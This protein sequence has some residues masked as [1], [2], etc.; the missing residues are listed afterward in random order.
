M[1]NFLPYQSLVSRL[2]AEAGASYQRRMLVVSGE[3]NWCDEFASWIHEEV[4]NE[5]SLWVSESPL[6]SEKGISANKSKMLLGREID[7]LVIDCHDGLDANALAASCGALCGGGLLVLLT[8][9]WER[10]ALLDR[11]VGDYAS[12]FIQHIQRSIQSAHITH[13]S[14]TG[15]LLTAPVNSSITA[16][17]DYSD[18]Q[19]AVAGVI[20][21][22]TGHR[23]R[24]LVITAD[25]GRGKSA[26]LGL[27]SAWLMRNSKLKI[28]V[29]AP[30]SDAVDAV[31]R[32]AAQ[33]LDVHQHGSIL[34]YE[35][36]KLEFIA[37]DELI[38]SSLE[39]DLVLVDE[40]AAIPVPMLA[41]LLKRY[42]RIAFSTTV[43]GYEGTGR[44][45][46]IRFR[47]KLD[48]LTPQ[49]KQLQLAKPVRWAENDPVE[50]WLFDLLF[51][52]AGVIK[53]TESHTVNLKKVRI[54]RLQQQELLKNP[55]LLKQIFGLLVLAHYQ[56]SPNDLR[57]MLD[58]PALQLWVTCYEDTVL[59]AALI[60]KEGPI[61]S[62]LQEAVWLGERRLRG[63]L[64]PQAL[65]AHSGFR[66][67]AQ[68]AYW[69]IM[70]ITVH[71]DFQR[72]GL[73]S[74]LLR[75][76]A[77]QALL[78]GVDIFGSSFAATED[79]CSFWQSAGLAM[80]RLGIS[81]DACSGAHS[82]VVLK[83][84][85]VRGKDFFDNVQDRFVEQFPQLLLEHF[86]DIESEL[87]LRL[88]SDFPVSGIPVL[89]QQDQL[90][91][92]AFSDGY[93][94]FESCSLALRKYFLS[95]VIL[96]HAQRQLTETRIGILTARVLQNKPWEKVIEDYSLKG[97]KQA[98]QLLREGF[99][100]LMLDSDFG[101]AK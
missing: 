44:G 40:A 49:W 79:V 43:H 64:L 7:L 28:I 2:H 87:V 80:V 75:A 81:R 63:Q 23:R 22:S 51:L 37:P 83:G 46:A 98:D 24:P 68:F 67:A 93:R 25:R 73:A 53:D 41:T 58:D 33:E 66:E 27:A 42:S 48:E 72:R 65:S 61:D 39:A 97:K 91:L 47:K 54:T 20:K 77:Q 99:S 76:I 101:S 11:S 88:L 36:S 69:R 12:L 5:H 32:H 84:L 34:V 19:L 29:T 59:A 56:T 62:A 94:L 90:D 96:G 100:R 74:K 17:P 86:Q 8:P 6:N 31:F 35:Q 14:Q 3:R 9:L 15:V 95:Q 30:R 16:G 92:L 82:A 13:I 38:R 89:N 55:Q 4:T 50:R 10:W 21:V 52:D 78:E 45:F 85:S 70:R 26:A 18:Q 60:V 57:I 1:N 71:P